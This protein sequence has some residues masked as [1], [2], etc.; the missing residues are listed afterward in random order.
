MVAPAKRPTEAWHTTGLFERGF[1]QVIIARFK[2]SGEAE[3]GVFLVD[4]FC[5]GVKDAYFTRLWPDEYE[6]RLLARLEDQGGREAIEP[7]CA[8]KL[9]EEA[10]VYARRL[11]LEPHPDYKL[12]A[13]VFGGIEA[14]SCPRTFVFGKDGKPL[15][16]QSPND[17]EA[18]AQHVMG[19]LT[20][21]LGQ[22]G[23]HYILFLGETSGGVGAGT[24]LKP[25][26]EPP[27]TEAGAEPSASGPAD[28]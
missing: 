23:F 14:R 1:G 4:T 6:K 9:V 15:Y 20:R 12:G 11:G 18:F 8:R 19:T 25:E 7:A 10:V 16:V 24:G 2:G 21:R 27:N 26:P 17:S 5:L 13:R 3:V 28:A 22:G